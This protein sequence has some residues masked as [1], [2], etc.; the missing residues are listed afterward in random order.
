M[1]EIT[2][3]DDETIEVD[4]WSDRLRIAYEM[5]PNVWLKIIEKWNSEEG[6]ASFDTA[7][8]RQLFLDLRIDG[9]RAVRMLQASGDTSVAPIDPRPEVALEGESQILE[10]ELFNE[11]MIFEALRDRKGMETLIL[12]DEKHAR[13]YADM[14]DTL[15]QEGVLKPGLLGL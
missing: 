2:I 13:V 12:G 14:H 5:R 7:P 6:S 9:E 3:N 11:D 4:F 10:D 8:I 15:K 1:Y